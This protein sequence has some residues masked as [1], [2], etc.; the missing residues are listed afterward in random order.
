[1]TDSI[2]TPHQ[3]RA[4]RAVLKW[5]QAE[6]ADKVGI[7]INS[8]KNIEA[9]TSQARPATLEKIKAIFER[10]DIEFLPHN[11][12]QRSDNKIKVYEDAQGYLKFFDEV[13]EAIRKNGAS[14]TI[15]GSQEL[16]FQKLS[17]EWNPDTHRDRMIALNKKNPINIRCIIEEGHPTYPGISYAEYRTVPSEIFPAVTTYVYE[18]KVGIF[19]WREPTKIIVVQDKDM[20]DAYRIQFE[21]HWE[22]GRPV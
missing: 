14:V 15:N 19:L 4:A 2:I 12:I 18:D 6:L 13:Y 3:I 22:K 8:I 1:M 7:N 11:G 21:L 5:T 16:N 17:G 20:A 9:E 10:Y